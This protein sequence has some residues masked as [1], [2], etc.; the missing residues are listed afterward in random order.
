MKIAVMVLLVISNYAFAHGNIDNKD[1]ACTLKVGHERSIHLSA[2]QPS[3]HEG[4]VFCQGAPDVVET[5]LVLDFM[6]EDSK[7]FPFAFSVGRMNKD[8]FEPISSLPF[9]L[10]PQGSILLTFSPEVEGKYRGE[11]VYLD[12]DGHDSKRE[13]DFYIGELG[14]NSREPSS[15]QQIVKWLFIAL[16]VFGGAYFVY[17]KRVNREEDEF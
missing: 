6:E 12:K 9:K 10:Y 8:V 15:T 11:V 13:F 14:P 1:G 4:E 7:G 2:Y 3:T 16:L 5:T 17:A